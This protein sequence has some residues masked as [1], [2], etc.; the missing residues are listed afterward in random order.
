MRETHKLVIQHI[1]SCRK[2][3]GLENS[4]IVLVLESNL[5]YEAQVLYLVDLSIVRHLT[6]PLALVS[7]AHPPQRAGRR[8]QEVGRYAS[9]PSNGPPDIL[10][11]TSL[12]VHAALQE[13]AGYTLG[14]LTTNERKEAMCLQLREALTVGKISFV[15]G[16]FSNTA[17]V[18]LMKQNC[19]DEMVS[20]TLSLPV[21]LV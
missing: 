2:I 21:C 6:H 11:D 4:T 1:A 14:W 9:A 5:A 19:E 10:T 16:F 18:K 3:K 12:C 13:G 8:A 7:T 15:D 17:S 20:T